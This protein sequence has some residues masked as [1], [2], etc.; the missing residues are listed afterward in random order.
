MIIK[1]FNTKGKIVVAWDVGIKNL[2]YATIEYFNKNNWK[3]LSWSLI[4][5][6]I[7]IKDNTVKKQSIIIDILN[8][9]KNKICPDDIVSVII[10][11]Q[12][13]SKQIMKIIQATIVTFYL[14]NNIK[15]SKIRIMRS[16]AKFAVDPNLIMP[17]NKKNYSKRKKMAILICYNCIKNNNRYKE[18]FNNA[19]KQDDLS[20]SLLM[21]LHYCGHTI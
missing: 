8:L 13:A 20:D 12:Q 11:S 21:A 2:S 4:N 18:Y 16:S 17:K 15:Y 7:Q 3:I 9:Y 6:N 1:R 14:N 5:T 19:K 10:E